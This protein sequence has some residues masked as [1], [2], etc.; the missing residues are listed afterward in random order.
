MHIDTL[1]DSN[2]QFEFEKPP[3]IN[4]KIRSI[5]VKKCLI[6]LKVEINDR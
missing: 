4:N 5:A 3:K 2:K 6:F 1:F